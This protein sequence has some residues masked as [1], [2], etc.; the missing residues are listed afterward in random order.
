MTAL[1]RSFSAVSGWFYRSRIE[2]RIS[3]AWRFFRLFP[4]ETGTNFRGAVEIAGLKLYN[5]GFQHAL[6]ELSVR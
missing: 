1:V 6:D 4:E 3:R 2:P 5:C